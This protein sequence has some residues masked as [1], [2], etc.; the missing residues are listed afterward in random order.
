RASSLVWAPRATPIGTTT[1]GIDSR[2][3]SREGRIGWRSLPSSLSHSDTRCL[4]ETAMKVH[5]SHTVYT[6]TDAGDGAFRI[7]GHEIYCPEP[8]LVTLLQPPRIGRCL[9]FR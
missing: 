8:L 1:T 2:A 7:S 6:L 9:I 5:T 3:N 4:Q